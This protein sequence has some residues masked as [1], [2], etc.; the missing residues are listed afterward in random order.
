MCK[1]YLRNLG[2]QRK[3]VIKKLINILL[4][5]V[6]WYIAVI[7]HNIYAA[8]IVLVLAFMNIIVMRYNYK[9]AIIIFVLAVLG[10][11]SDAIM[12]NLGVYSFAY[13]NKFFI[14]DNLW[15]LSLWIIFLTTFNSSL[16][17]LKNFKIYWLCIMGFLGGAFSYFIA[18]K[19]KVINFPDILLS[20]F[21]IGMIWSCIFPALYKAYQ[22][23]LAI[24]NYESF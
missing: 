5:Y 4:F 19:L 22:R 11:T 20:L 23:I 12:H 7:F 15:L 3:I 10:S 16:V 9:E 14:L 1:Y 24:N 21:Y 6:G 13:T 17:F 2:I 8:V 18:F